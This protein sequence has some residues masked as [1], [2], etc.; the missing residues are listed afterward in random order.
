M[1]CKWEWGKISPK[2]C[3]IVIFCYRREILQAIAAK[4]VLH[5]TELQGVLIPSHLKVGLHCVK[6]DY[7]MKSVVLCVDTWGYFYVC[8]NW[9][10]QH[11]NVEYGYPFFFPWL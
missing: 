6:N 1:R 7:I 11:K 5:A 2:Q 9:W 8:R 10:G 4:K 3:E